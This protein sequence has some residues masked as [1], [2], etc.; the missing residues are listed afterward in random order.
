MK[1][2]VSLLI[3]S[4]LITISIS[5]FLWGHSLIKAVEN[6]YA[7]QKQ[8]A[9]VSQLGLTTILYKRLNTFS[10]DDLRWQNTA[11]VLAKSDGDIAFK[12]ATYFIGKGE[13]SKKY[14]RTIELWLLQAVRLKHHKAR[15]LLSKVYVD[16][17][18]FAAAK[19]L[20]LPIQSEAKA[21]KILIEISML[22]GGDE[23][24]EHYIQ[25]F[26][27]ISLLNINEELRGFYQQLKSYHVIEG[28]HLAPKNNC[29]A[30]IAP[31]ATN[32]KNL[33]YFDKLISSDKLTS[34][35]PYLCFS[36]VKYISKKELD[37]QHLGDEAIRCAE[38]IW[39]NKD[40]AH[41]NRF[42]AVLVENGGANV[43]SGILYID[44]HD[45]VE[46]FFHELAHLLGF[47][48]EYPLPKNHFRCLASQHTMF[49][50]NIAVLPRFYKGTRAVVRKQILKK[51]PWAKYI[52]S[53]T[54]IVSETEQGWKIGT[55]GDNVNTVGVFA[56]ETCNE[57]TFLAVK[58]LN[59]RTAMRYYEEIFP[60]LYFQL[61]ADNPERFL[62]PNYQ[63]NVVEALR[64]KK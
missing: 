44:S 21:L 10:E 50:H 49:S 55:I 12:L 25:K 14:H 64:V 4:L 57:Q 42:V 2:K 29:L 39:K 53:D 27:T 61:L 41:D 9:Y 52:S 43:N 11:K 30:T 34:L 3:L 1:A 59:Q 63:E 23:E 45:N 54:Q 22:I 58:P 19:K 31:F 13:S 46:V 32:L 5:S 33:V 35:K 38:S 37:C 48:D 28:Q 24:L 6:G 17:K 56:A 62:M 7:S 40:L 51:L 26:K 8:L 47:I 60:P 36:P 15:I 20:L 18:R 16:N